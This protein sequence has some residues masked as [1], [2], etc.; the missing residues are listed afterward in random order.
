MLKT[1]AV[2]A[3][4][5]PGV[6]SKWLGG[7]EALD[8]LE[9]RVQTGWSAVMRYLVL[10]APLPVQH[11]QLIADPSR[12]LVEGNHVFCS[13]GGK[14]VT[15]STHV[16]LEGLSKGFLDGVQARLGETLSLRAGEVVAQTQSSMNASPRT[17]QRFTG[18]ANGA[19]GG[20]PRRFG[21]HNYRGLLPDAVRPGFWLVG[22]SQFPGQSTL[23][24]ALGGAR[25]AMRIR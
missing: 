7:V 19:V 1:R 3:N 23:A 16:P 15:L 22:D 14:T 12:P 5:L 8:R 24:T 6:A 9:A 18:R 21:W 20:I 2:I 11:L 10:K 25:V 13:V 17:F 4:V